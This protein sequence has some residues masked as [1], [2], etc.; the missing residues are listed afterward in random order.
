LDSRFGSAGTRDMSGGNCSSAGR[1]SGVRKRR[2]GGSAAAGRK[3]RRPATTKPHSPKLG[4]CA[5]Y[6][7]AVKPTA[8][9]VVTTVQK[10]RRA[11][12]GE[13][14]CTTAKPPAA[15]RRSSIW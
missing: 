2:P 9:S 4:T 5:W 13:V 1:P 7:V 3:G 11:T 15:S 12:S 6:G 8:S 14:V 10:L